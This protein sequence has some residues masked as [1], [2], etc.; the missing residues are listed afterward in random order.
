MMGRAANRASTTD[1][2]RGLVPV[3]LRHLQVHQHQVER[4]RLRAIRQGLD[5][6]ASVVGDLHGGADAFEQLNRDLLVDLVVLGEQNARAQQPACRFLRHRAAAAS[7]SSGA[8]NT[9]TS[10]STSMDLVTGLT[11]KPSR[12]SR[13]ASSRTSSRPNAVTITMAG[14][15]GSVSSLLIWRLACRPSIPGMRQSMKTMS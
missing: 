1:L 6:L 13:S 12:P 2:R 7:P 14:C 9:L 15:F 8:A 3:H 11:R 4:R 5:R 10:V